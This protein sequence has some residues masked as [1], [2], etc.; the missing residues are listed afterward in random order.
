MKKITSINGVDVYLH[1]GDILDV[2]AD[3]IA[4]SVDGSGPGLEGNLA[5]QLMGQ[6]EVQ[7]MEELYAPPPYYPFNGDCYWSDLRAFYETPFQRICCL[8]FL[9]HQPGH[10]HKAYM[11]SAFS[12]MMLEGGLGPDFGQRIACPV[13][14]GGYRIKLVDAL[15]TMFNV[16]ED[17]KHSAVEEL[18]LVEQDAEKF[19]IMLQVAQSYM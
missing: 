18:V 12:K 16:L 6:L 11:A 17:V 5:R 19:E 7:K 4:V 8:G 10:N 9:S 15:Y 14:T 13:L 3:T 1:N 2:R